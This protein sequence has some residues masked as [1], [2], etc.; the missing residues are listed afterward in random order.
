MEWIRHEKTDVRFCGE[1]RKM[2]RLEPCTL[3]TVHMMLLNVKC[4]V[5]SESVGIACCILEDECVRWCALRFLHGWRKSSKKTAGSS[6]TRRITKYI[7]FNL[8]CVLWK[9]AVSFFGMFLAEYV[10]VFLCALVNM[11]NVRHAQW[12]WS[13][14]S[15]FFVLLNF[16]FNYFL[17]AFRANNVNNLFRDPDRCT[18]ES[19]Q[20]RG[21]RIA[22]AALRKN[23]KKLKQNTKYV[24][25]MCY[26]WIPTF[27]IY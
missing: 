17:F 20:K 23:I 10:C 5:R 4:D 26:V 1:K 15:I 9:T 3:H 18:H 14:I 22:P 13:G 21:L 11:Q 19:K 8:N 16:H 2:K 12:M 25:W 27:A 24:C 7:L 6:K